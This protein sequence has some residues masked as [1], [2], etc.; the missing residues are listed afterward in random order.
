MNGIQKAISIAGGREPLRKRL[1]V[2]YESVRQW[3]AQG[4]VPHTSVFAVVDET[5]VS[6]FELNPTVYPEHRF[7]KAS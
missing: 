1:G 7:K 4:F 5:G 6:C 2:S 3:E